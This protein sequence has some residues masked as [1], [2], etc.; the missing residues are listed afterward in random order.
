MMQRM[1]S[2]PHTLA[3][4]YAMDALSGRDRSRFRRHLAWCE[5]CSHV[6]T[7]LRETAARKTL[8]ATRLGGGRK[9]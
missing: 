9:R 7:S 6:V 3:A 5:A 8:D 2:D 4:A 1:T